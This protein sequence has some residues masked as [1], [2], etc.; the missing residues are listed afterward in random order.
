MDTSSLPPY[1]PPSFPPPSGPPLLP[2]RRRGGRGRFAATVLVGALV[3]G[4]GAGV[5]GAAAWSAVSGP[6]DGGT[7]ASSLN[8]DASPIAT[9]SGK[10]VKV[11]SVESVAKTVLPSVVEIDVTGGGSGGSGSGVVLDRSGLILTNNHVVTLDSSVDAQQ[12][13]ITVSFNDGDKLAATVVGTDP[14]TDTALVRV[15]GAKDLQPITIGSSGNLQVGQQ[16]VAVG[17]PY[18]LDST[19]TSGIVS[20]LDRPVDVGQDQNGNTTAYPAIQTDAAINPGNSGGALV[21]MAGRLVGINAS[22]QTA[23]DGMGSGQG[24]SIGLGF[25]I[26]INEILPIV[27]QL[28]AGQ[29]PTHARLG[30]EI[31]DAVAQSATTTEGAQIRDVTAES[32]AAGAGLRRGDV[33]TGID[34]H[35]VTS[36]DSLIATI[37]ACRPDQEVT[38]TYERGGTSHTTRL[39]LGSDASSGS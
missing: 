1:G 25:A 5:G 31:S 38:V 23:S 33:I 37:R 4:G 26:P 30:I 10:T 8:V 27:K 3:V 19:V 9:S 15:S 21:D 32:A 6:S 2:P 24:G 34:D 20:A 36:A 11:G 13:Q 16:V 14:L 35:H 7:T 22:I 29:T 18:G 17:S 39:R 12:T 28:E